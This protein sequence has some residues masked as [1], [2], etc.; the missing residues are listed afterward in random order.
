MS[1]EQARGQEVDSRSDIWSLGVVLYQMIVGRTPFEDKSNTDTL[2]A[3]LTKEPPPL[4]RS[5][6]EVP[7]ELQRIV[8]KMLRKEKDQRYQSAKDVLIDLQDQQKNL[9]AVSRPNSIEIGSGT[10]VKTVTHSKAFLAKGKFI[11]GALVL[12]LLAASVFVVWRVSNRTQ[13]VIDNPRLQGIVQL[14]SW[15]GLDIHPSLSPDANAIAYSSDHNGNFEIYVKPLTPGGREIQITNDGQ[16]NFQPVWSP[17]GQ[18]LAYYSKNQG[19][20]WIVPSSGGKA[21]QVSQFGAHP[22]WSPDGSELAFQSDPITD[23]G[24]Q[25]S[26]SQPPSLIWIVAKNGTAPPKQITQLGHPAG[27]HG[28]PAWSRDGKHLA[29]CV[30]DYGATSI[31]IIERDGREPKQAIKYGFDPAY[32][33]DGKSLYYTTLSGI[34]KTQISEDTGAPIGEPTQ[35]SSSSSERIRGFAISAD[36]KKIVY[37]AL[38]TNSNIWYVPISPAT[39]I[40][41]GNPIALTH[42][43]T[44]RNSLPVFSPD[45]KRIAFNTQ[46]ANPGS[47][48][49]DVWLMDH[50]GQRVTQITTEGGGMPGWFPGADRLAFLTSRD[51]KK[52]WIANLMTG[53]DSTSTLDFGEDINYARLSPD[54]KQVLFNSKRSGTTNVWKVSIEGGNPK[55]LTFDNEME[56]FA[57]WSPDGKMIG[58]QIKRGG[59]TNIGI[60]PSDGGP[61]TQ[62]TFDKGQSWLS[63]FSPDGDKLVFAGFREGVWNICWVSRSTREQKRITNYTRLNSFVR[64]P[65]WSPLGNQI[66][67]EYAETTGNIW[68]ADI[69]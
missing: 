35:L 30:S 42:D 51:S 8:S 62:L 3:I 15:P 16:S 44:F 38:L 4:E 1:P 2:A 31:W 17:D 13:Q 22:A 47:S 28:A 36:G 63:S 18:W 23:L 25:A 10:D 67:Y 9:R 69:K 6:L 45:G 40:A 58:V 20:I 14:T 24:A 60:M 34:W 7:P 50:D 5:P 29:I 39:S 11:F 57:C 66:A 19:G 12:L 53:Q 59:D 49:G 65:N 55:Q 64:Y 33:P 54:G 27:G 26:P 43:T 46:K 52:L 61:V 68:V 48:E 37:S 56:G 21:K 41:T 32:G